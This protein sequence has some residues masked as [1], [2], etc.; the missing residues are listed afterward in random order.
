MRCCLGA[1][2]GPM[3]P[4]LPQPASAE[5]Q[6]SPGKL[7]GRLWASPCS[8]L[9]PAS[10]SVAV[11]PARGLAEA[12]KHPDSKLCLG[13]VPGAA[14]TRRPLAACR[15]PIAAAAVQGSRQSLSALLLACPVPRKLLALSVMAF[16]CP[17]A[18]AGLWRRSVGWPPTTPSLFTCA[19][20]RCLLAAAR[21]DVGCVVHRRAGR[22]HVPHCALLPACAAS[23]GCPNTCGR[24]AAVHHCL[25]RL[26][27]CVL[28]CV[29][30]ICAGRS[31]CHIRAACALQESAHTNTHQHACPGGQQ[32][33]HC[34]CSN[35][36]PHQ[37]PPNAGGQQDVITR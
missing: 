20:S 10:N 33:K 3:E 8:L 25:L 34:C 1:A 17:Q 2:G 24:M 37:S 18:G 5:E 22:Q 16:H 35:P 4:L 14:P 26:H 31:S 32:N 9:K 29:I 19:V 36:H 28:R 11:L 15:P 27:T 12:D 30:V 23:S 6:S 21:F 13:V 7:P